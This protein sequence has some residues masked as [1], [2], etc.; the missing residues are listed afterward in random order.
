ME[1]K[2]LDSGQWRDSIA[3]DTVILFNGIV[4]LLTITNDN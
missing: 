3:A 2:W 4:N 1:T